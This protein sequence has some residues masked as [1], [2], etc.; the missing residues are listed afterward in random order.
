MHWTPLALS[1]PTR[2]YVFGGT[3]IADRYGR[4]DHGRERLAE[5]WE[6]S[7]VDGSIGEIV[8]GP[9]AGKSLREVTLAHPDEVVGRGW[10]GAHFPILTK[11]LDASH[12][13][14]VHLHAD[15]EVAR[16]L[17]AAPH[18]KTEAW[19][20][21]DAAPGASALV[22]TKPGVD[23]ATLRDALLR[24]DFDAVMRRL[25]IRAGETIYVPGGTLHTFGPDTLIY[26]IQQT[27]DIGQHA[28]TW[29]LDGSTI[30]PGE[31]A[32][33]IDRLIAQWRPD[34]RPLP[35]LPLQVAVGPDADRAICCAGP[36]FALERWRVGAG[37]RLTHTFDTALILSNVGAPAAIHASETRELAMGR[38]LLLPA[39]IGEVSVDG[40]ADVLVGYLPN[41]ERDICE[42]LRR[43]GF[44]AAA[45]AGL[46]DVGGV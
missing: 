14:P 4:T 36:Y 21:L 35:R 41:L 42:P 5:T 15:D 34:P 22:G 13:L 33:N 9:F 3:R 25:P 26:E 7:D 46:G 2:A 30:P 40:P 20:I 19:H 8:D 27:S 18:G 12:L 39:A 38:S 23:A 43:A 6:V 45:I 1:T 37:A 29:R 16:R 10:R 28:M 11:F 31:R 44:G 24:Q 17:E 32:E